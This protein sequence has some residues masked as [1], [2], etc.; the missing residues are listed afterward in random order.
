MGNSEE[1]NIGI[2]GGRG[3]FWKQKVPLQPA[4]SRTSSFQLTALEKTRMLSFKL[5]WVDTNKKI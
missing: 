3:V 5:V 1:A 2:F 4:R